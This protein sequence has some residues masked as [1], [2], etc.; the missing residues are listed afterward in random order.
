V[1]GDEAA[2]VLAER[3][4]RMVTEQIAGRGV[5]DRE[6]LAALRAVPR[7]LFVPENLV[8][9]AYRDCALPI[10][11]GQTISQPYIVAL[12][13]SLLRV[14]V[15]SRVLEVG[16]GSGYQTAVLAELAGEVFTIER[17]PELAARAQVALRGLGYRNV[18]TRVGDGSVGLP[19]HQPYDGIM[20]TAAAPEPPKALLR[21]MADGGRLVLPI[22]EPGRD[23]MLV[24]LVRQG[25]S[26][27][28]R[29]QI[30]VRFVP[31][32]GEQG[33]AESA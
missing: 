10:G 26:Y 32:V 19:E 24:L 17:V 33:F 27:T 16:S 3:R 30:G 11:Y 12:M 31:L 7:H 2:A 6:V 22:G 21:Q 23:Q 13:T 15:R 28:E 25:D 14:D 29:E 18:T 20:V 9:D 1:T 8:H 4:R 5:D